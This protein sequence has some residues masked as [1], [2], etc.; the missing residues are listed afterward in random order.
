VL[1][2]FRSPGGKDLPNNMTR[3]NTI[4][5][6]KNRRQSFL[7]LIARHRI[8]ID[9][10]EPATKTHNADERVLLAHFYKRI[11]EMLKSRK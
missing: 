8:V 2:N 6:V 9:M 3:W 11:F 10:S 7:W 1:Q 5:Q 4:R